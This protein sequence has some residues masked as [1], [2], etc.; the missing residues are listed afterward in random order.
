MQIV[1]IVGLCLQSKNIH[2][3]LCQRVFINIIHVHNRTHV[4]IVHIPFHQK[5]G[6]KEGV[7]VILLTSIQTPYFSSIFEGYV[8]SMIVQLIPNLF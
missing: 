7:C 2:V 4:C 5:I 6:Q 1:Y 8:T 3:M